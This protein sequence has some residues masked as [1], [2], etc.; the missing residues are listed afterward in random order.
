M[1]IVIVSSAGL[2]GAGSISDY[3]LSRSDFTS[4]FKNKTDYKQDYEFRMVTDPCGIDNI[5]RNFYENFSINN[6]AYAYFQLENYISNL[7]KI[8]DVKSNKPIYSDFF[9][10]QYDYYIKKIVKFS[11]YGLPQHYAIS[12]SPYSKLIWRLLN[13]NKKKFAQETNFYKMVIPVEKKIFLNLTNKFLLKVITQHDSSKKNVVVD[14]GGNFWNP[15]SS[16]KYFTNSKVIQVV[17]DPKAIFSSMKTRKSLS[18]PGNDINLFIKWF[19]EIQAR[20][21]LK[22]EKKVLQVKFEDFILKHEN[23]KVKINNFLNLKNQKT[24]FNL[25]NSEKNIKKY[26]E[27]LNK[28]EISKINSELKKFIYF[29]D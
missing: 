9:F 10:K 5:Y 21:N 7:K 19:K 11:Y 22:E 17:R 1:K 13:Y 6:A 28:N 20:R 24:D 4:P 2:S 8:K 25:G 12:M 29:N 18:Y 16:T 23:T 15:V 3:L 14:Q 26:K 27:N